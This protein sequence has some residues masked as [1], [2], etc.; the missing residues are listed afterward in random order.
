MSKALRCDK[1]KQCFVPTEAEG[2]MVKFRNP[3]LYTAESADNSKM[4]AKVSYGFPELGP[5]GMV[6]LCPECSK[7]FLQYMGI[8]VVCIDCA[9]KLL[10]E[11]N[12]SEPNVG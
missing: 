10:E 11:S 3:I 4:T 6:D 5:D 12:A 8:K 9:N 7:G 2:I 1:C